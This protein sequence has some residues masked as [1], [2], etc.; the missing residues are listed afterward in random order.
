MG[1][2][3]RQVEIFMN[4]WNASNEAKHMSFL[5]T[6]SFG[7][8]DSSIPAAAGCLQ[9]VF[10]YVWGAQWCQFWILVKNNL[11]V[12]MSRYTY[13]IMLVQ[14]RAGSSSTLFKKT[15]IYVQNFFS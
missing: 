3:L 8:V 4:A 10:M 5:C 11:R 9:Y 13:L 2:K 1:E 6:C 15:Q 7:G 12:Q 14:G